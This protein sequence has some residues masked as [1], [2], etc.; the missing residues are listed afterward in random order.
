[1]YD[2]AYDEW[3]NMTV[4]ERISWCERNN[5]ECDFK[6]ASFDAYEL[7]ENKYCLWTLIREILMEE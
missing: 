5:I 6:I 7:S 1:M 2:K 4:N 3:D